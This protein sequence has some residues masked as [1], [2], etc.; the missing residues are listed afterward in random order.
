[1]FR[2]L[3]GK[4]RKL[5]SITTFPFLLINHF[6]PILWALWVLKEVS[7]RYSPSCQITSILRGWKVGRRVGFYPSKSTLSPLF[8]PTQ[9]M[10]VIP[11]HFLLS[12]RSPSSHSQC[13]TSESRCI[14]NRHNTGY[15]AYTQTKMVNLKELPWHHAPTKTTNNPTHIY[16]SGYMLVIQ[17]SLPLSQGTQ[18]WHH[19]P[20][21]NLGQILKWQW[22]TTISNQRYPFRRVDKITYPNVCF[23][24]FSSSLFCKTRATLSHYTE[25]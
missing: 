24:Q 6:I 7:L 20:Q 12:S 13:E 1:M 15:Y 11:S 4:M 23:I 8:T 21:K 14:Y 3:K 16:G 5:M 9:D 19:T 2:H 22:K 25:N 17:Q 10:D 18:L